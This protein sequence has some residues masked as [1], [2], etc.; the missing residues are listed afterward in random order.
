[1]FAQRCVVVYNVAMNRLQ[2]IEERLNKYVD[3][4]N[5]CWNWTRDVYNYGYGKLS[6]GRGKQTRAHRYVYIKQ[7]GEIPEGMNVLHK[8]DNPRCVNP[9][10]LFLGTQKDNVI[11]MMS[12]GRGGYK[13]F[14][15]ENHANSKLTMEKASEIRDMYKTGRYFQREIGERFGISQAVVSKIIMGTSW[16]RNGSEVVKIKR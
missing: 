15:G 3:K 10:H 11:D 8:C 14:F 16:T 9:S 13:T 12:R 5:T 7:F 1:M 6:I 2:N 4:T